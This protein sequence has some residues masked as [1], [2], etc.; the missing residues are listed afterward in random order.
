MT[1]IIIV[2]GWAS[3]KESLQ[4]L[5]DAC[6]LFSNVLTISIH[7]LH[8]GYAT[9]L[10]DIINDAGGNCLLAGW[11][12]GGMAVLE[13]AVHCQ[14]KIDGMVLISTTSRFSSSADYDIGTSPSVLRA[15]ISG[16]KKDART[17]LTNFLIN[18]HKPFMED[19]ALVRKE[20]DASCLIGNEGLIKGLRY[21][22]DTDLRN[23]LK[24]IKIPSLVI[25]GKEDSIIPW[26]AGRFLAERLPNAS[27]K[28]IEGA[29]HDLPIRFSGSIAEEVR[30]FTKMI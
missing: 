29:G 22:K 13:A 1:K 9:G 3:P 7:D 19:T 16:I 21:L 6:S 25:H 5:S 30:R 18:T 26:Q 28:L 20:A 8:S 10:M 2:S 17:T 15:M 14:D 27:F 23:L 12:T 11:S 4:K 24:N